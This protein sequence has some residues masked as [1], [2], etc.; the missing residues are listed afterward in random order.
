MGQQYNGVDVENPR[1]AEY[2][3]NAIRQ[4][5]EKERIM[6]V[7]GIPGE[8]VDRYKKEVEREERNKK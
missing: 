3:K 1:I 5:W 8:V 4:G 6:K 2:T 7:I